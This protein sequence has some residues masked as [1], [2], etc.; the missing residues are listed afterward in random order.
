MCLQGVCS[1]WGLR[2]AA[3]EQTIGRGGGLGFAIFQEIAGV[4]ENLGSGR[5][6]FGEQSGGL[7]R[8]IEGGIAGVTFGAFRLVDVL[9]EP[10]F[11]PQGFVLG[12]G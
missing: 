10:S 4:L 8:Q 9:V 6:V 7:K 3:H 11:D 5:I 1:V 12:G 2:E